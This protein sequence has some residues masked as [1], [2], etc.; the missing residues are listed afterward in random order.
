MTSVSKSNPCLQWMRNS[1]IQWTVMRTYLGGGIISVQVVIKFIQDQ[2]REFIAIKLPSKYDKKIKHTVDC[3]MCTIYSS[4]G[5]ECTIGRSNTSSIAVNAYK[6]CNDCYFVFRTYAKRYNR[7]YSWILNHGL[8]LELLKDL[9]CMAPPTSNG[10]LDCNVL[11]KM[12]IVNAAII[13]TS[14]KEWYRYYEVLCQILN[15]DVANHI[16]YI[17]VRT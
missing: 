11:Q 7:A 14:R 6:M 4:F 10:S 2:S 17:T 15:I 3:P 5:K 1:T 16:I 9:Y 8:Q 13:L 12:T